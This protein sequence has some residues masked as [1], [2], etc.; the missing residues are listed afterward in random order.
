MVVRRECMILKTTWEHIQKILLHRRNYQQYRSLQNCWVPTSI[1]KYI[2][3]PSWKLKLKSEWMHKIW[4][5]L[6]IYFCVTLIHPFIS[7]WRVYHCVCS[8]GARNVVAM[9]TKFAAKLVRSRPNVLLIWLSSSCHE[10]IDRVRLPDSI[11]V[12][13]CPQS[14]MSQALVITW[15]KIIYMIILQISFR[16]S[17]VSSPP[18][19]FALLLTDLQIYMSHHICKLVLWI[20]CSSLKV[21]AMLA[22]FQF[23]RNQPLSP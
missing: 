14:E 7:V 2:T 9:R 12:T 13:P 23:A 6:R 20:T 19:W 18:V 1:E 5:C 22:L 8:Q 3:V 11:R 15:N 4:R 21:W 10:W 17:S 16:V